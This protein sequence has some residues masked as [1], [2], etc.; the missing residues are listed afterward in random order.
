MDGEM[1]IL[2]GSLGQ[3]LEEGLPLIIPPI[4]AIVKAEHAALAAPSGER[5][6][7][8]LYLR[9]WWRGIYKDCLKRAYLAVVS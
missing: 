8:I 7:T 9:Y 5:L 2:D 3:K 1:W 6:Y 4:C